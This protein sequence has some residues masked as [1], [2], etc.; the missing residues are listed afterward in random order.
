MNGKEYLTNIKSIKIESSNV[1]NIEKKYKSKLPLIIQQII[2]YSNNPVFLDED[3]KVLSYKE[4]LKASEELH[5]DFNKYR[6]IPLID[7][8]DNDFISYNF[9]KKEYCIFN[10]NDYCIFKNKPRLADY[11]EE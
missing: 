10:V 1:Q 9:E 5:V 11:F 6:L 4:I 8:Y 7:C 3:K 2:S